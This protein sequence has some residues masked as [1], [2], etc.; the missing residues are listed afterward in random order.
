MLRSGLFVSMVAI[1]GAAQAASFPI[2]GSYGDP[3]SCAAFKASG[4]TGAMK[5]PGGTLVLP[6][7]FLAQDRECVVTGKDKLPGIFTVTCHGAGGEVASFANVEK[8]KSGIWFAEGKAGSIF[9]RCP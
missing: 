5:V 7:R 3:A 4:T 2:T 6:D 1:A 8:K 9:K